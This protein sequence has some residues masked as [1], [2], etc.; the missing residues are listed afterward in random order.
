MVAARA[1]QTGRPKSV[2][3]RGDR[4]AARRLWRPGTRPV[5][6]DG[7]HILGAGFGFGGWDEL[8]Q[9][10]PSSTRAVTA[11]LRTESEL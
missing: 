3:R 7:A 2:R 11:A 8:W 10:R 1:A 6:L 4:G 5:V 9:P